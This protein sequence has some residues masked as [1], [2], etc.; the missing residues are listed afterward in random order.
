MGGI[1][2]K[3][4]FQK[5]G[6][7]K[8]V[9]HEDNEG[10]FS[11]KSDKICIEEK[12]D[13]C[14]VRLMFKDGK[15]IFGSRTQQLTDDEGKDTNVQKNFMRVINFIREQVWSN[16][17]ISDS[18]KYEKYIFYGEGCIKHTMN[19]DWDKI[20][21]FLGFDIYDKEKECYIEANVS[22]EIFKE[23]GL[24]FVPIIKTIKAGE[25]KE[26]NEDMIPTSKYA[27]HQ[28]EGICFKNYKKQ[29]FAKLVQEKFK[30]KNK[31]VF[32]GGKKL[33]KTDEEFL[34]AVYC[35]NARIDK[36][37]F[38]LIDEGEKLDLVMM[39][40]LPNRVY[41]DI[42]EENMMEIINMKGK[43][44]GFQTFR[45]RVTQR[46]FSVLNQVIINNALNKK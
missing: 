33:A 13:G 6:K 14:N 31:E 46:C 10:I 35:T 24:S 3:M 4:E 7:I 27:P 42:W 44:I 22:K 41:K 45:K 17:D 20:P 25:I 21:P 12:I 39:K 1:I 11:D 23:V 26:L 29:L 16:I 8:I 15:L 36:M 18:K 2:Y 43:T 19:Y 38:K 9:G 30:E 32:G 37:I 28:A 5:Y 40:H 34:T